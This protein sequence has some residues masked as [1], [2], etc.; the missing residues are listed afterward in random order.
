M[1]IDEMENYAIS[2]GNDIIETH[3]LSDGDMWRLQKTPIKRR[4]GPSEGCSAVQPLSVGKIVH[5]MSI[6]HSFGLCECFVTSVR[7]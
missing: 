3:I 1:S 6:T 5:R 2:I 7:S 4:T